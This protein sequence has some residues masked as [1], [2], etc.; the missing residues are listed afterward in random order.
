MKFLVV[1]RSTP[2]MTKLVMTEIL[3]LQNLQT[4]RGAHHP[5]VNWVPGFFSR[6]VGGDY[7]HSSHLVPKLR[8]SGAIHFLPPYAFMAWIGRI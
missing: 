1:K 6:G 2:P 5:A 8:M 7:D 3:L 4:V